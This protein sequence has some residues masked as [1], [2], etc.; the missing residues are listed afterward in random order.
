MASQQ[1]LKLVQRLAAGDPAAPP[2]IVSLANAGDPDAELK[3]AEFCLRGIGGRPNFEIARALTARAADKG[4]VESRRALAYFTAAGIGRPANRHLARQMLESLAGT[5]RKVAAQ[6]RFADQMTCQKRLQTAERRQL[7][8]EPRVEIIPQLFSAAECSYIQ[9]LASPLLEP[10]MVYT[11]AGEGIRDPHRD[12]D[13]MVVTPILE[14]LVV[15]AINRCI[16][17]ASGTGYNWGEP[18][19]V[20]RYSPGQQYRPHYDAHAFMPVAQRRLTTAIIYL[21][22]DYDGGETDFPELGVRARGEAGDL[23]IFQN[24]LAD[25]EPDMRMIHAGLPV[26]RGEKWLATRW[27]RVGDFFGRG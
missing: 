23:L 1:Y 24:L 25:K 18:L 5:D 20:L 8:V 15:Q 6:L 11:E 22:D 17:E 26:T 12:S 13:N 3:T 2:A 9:S 4:H 14:D 16:A 10:A 7:S 19:H 21:N 27:I